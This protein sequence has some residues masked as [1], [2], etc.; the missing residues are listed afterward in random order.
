MATD[1]I[2]QE[3]RTQVL[4]MYRECL[5]NNAATIIPM[6]Y[7]VD[8]CGLFEPSCPNDMVC[9]SCRCHRN[10]HSRLAVDIPHAQ[11]QNNVVSQQHGTS[12][13]PVLLH[14]HK[15]I[16][17]RPQAYNYFCTDPSNSSSSPKATVS[18]SDIHKT[19]TDSCTNRKAGNESA[20]SEAG[21]AGSG[22]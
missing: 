3:A 12:T 8:G 9:A 19:C 15:P 6:A 5:H 22:G 21:R 10:F 18:S 7:T 16:R 13:N 20:I 4:V 17:K 14:S 2:S 1:N 11:I